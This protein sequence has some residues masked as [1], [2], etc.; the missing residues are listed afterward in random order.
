M[1]RIKTF[2]ELNELSTSTY[3]NLMNKTTDYPWTHFFSKNPDKDINPKE[4]GTQHGRINTLARDKF[5][6]EF[7][8]EFPIGSIVIDTNKGEYI[9]DGI[10]F[11]TNYT[12]Y[13]LI[14]KNGSLHDY[15]WIVSEK[16]GYYIDKK[17]IEIDDDKSDKIINELLKYNTN[18]Q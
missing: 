17:D 13:D 9:F 15:L 18:K 8:K 2:S 16:E 5:I 14:F 10:K 11:K 1:K 4:L 3:A 12:Y 6:S 7:Y